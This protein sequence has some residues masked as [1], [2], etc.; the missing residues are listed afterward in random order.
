MIYTDPVIHTTCATAEATHSGSGRALVGRVGNLIRP[1]RLWIGRKGMRSFASLPLRETTFP[2][3]YLNQGNPCSRQRIHGHK[4]CKEARLAGHHPY[5]CSGV[6]AAATQPLRA[7][8]LDPF[9]A[10]REPI[11]RRRDEE[12]PFRSEQRT[13]LMLVNANNCCKSPPN[14]RYATSWVTR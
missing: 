5:T 11:R 10:F 9:R 8:G 12:R 4:R 14:E 7:S 13:W 3:K 1:S 6:K 2:V